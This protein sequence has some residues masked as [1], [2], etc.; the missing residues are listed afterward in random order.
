MKRRAVCAA[1]GLL[2]ASGCLRLQESGAGQGGTATGSGGSQSAAGSGDGQASAAATDESSDDQELSLAARVT[3]DRDVDYAWGVG[4]QFYYNGDEG[5]TAATFDGEIRWRGEKSAEN[6]GSHLGA[7]A[8]AIDDTRVVFGFTADPEAEGA[9]SEAGAHYYAYH[10]VTGEEQW[11]VTMPADGNHGH[12]NGAAIVDGTAVLTSSAYGP[13]SEQD[14]TVYGVD[15]ETGA[16]QWVLGPPDIPADFVSGVVGHDGGVFVFLGTQGASLVDPATGTVDTH[17]EDMRVDAHVGEPT[18]RA[19]AVY[20]YSAGGIT[21]YR[22][23]DGS[24]IWTQDDIDRP[25]TQPAADN[26]LVVAGT[27]TG[28]IHAFDRASGDRLWETSIERAVNA[29]ELTASHVWVAD[30]ASGLYAYARDDGEPVHRFT[31]SMDGDDIAIVP[32]NLLI[33]GERTV[34]SIQT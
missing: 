2:G 8:F 30:L 18:V 4:E 21:A 29:V 7:D 16:R 24:E 13:D 5:S 14:P 15:V 26:S 10:K 23:D 31:Y 20:A 6:G 12:A 19:E 1:L 17:R 34:Y 32:D 28:S 11:V 27:S 9:L 25:R 33:G 22:L 3:N